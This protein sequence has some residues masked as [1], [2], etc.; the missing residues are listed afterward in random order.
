MT[1]PREGAGL[2]RY[3]LRSTQADPPDGP[4]TDLSGKHIVIIGDQTGFGAVVAARFRAAGACPSL[5]D[6]S[7]DPDP[8]ALQ[9]LLDRLHARHETAAGLVVCLTTAADLAK[10]GLADFD[11]PTWHRLDRKSTRLNSSHR[12]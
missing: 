2:A 6:F 4:R 1:S 10:S 7:P 11:P 9:T 8:A 5:L 12:R 3:I